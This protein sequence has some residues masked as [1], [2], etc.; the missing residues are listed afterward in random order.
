MSTALSV[1]SCIVDDAITWSIEGES[2][3]VVANEG[4]RILSDPLVNFGE[5]QMPQRRFIDGRRANG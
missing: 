1:Q 4:E 3:G 2:Y 5:F